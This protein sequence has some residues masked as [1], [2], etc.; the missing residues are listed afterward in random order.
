MIEEWFGWCECFPLFGLNSDVESAWV[1]NDRR[2]VHSKDLRTQ[3]SI[4]L[5]IPSIV[6][7]KVTTP[8]DMSWPAMDMIRDTRLR[9]MDILM[10][11]AREVQW[12]QINVGTSVKKGFDLIVTNGCEGENWRDAIEG[13]RFL[14]RKF[15]VGVSA[16]GWHFGFLRLVVRFATIGTVLVPV[17]LVEAKL[18]AELDG[19]RA[20]ASTNFFPL[21]GKI[22]ELSYLP[23]TTWSL[24][25]SSWWKNLPE[26]TED[27]ARYK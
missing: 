20:I 15:S 25:N 19:T 7:Q 9:S 1:G 11:L 3:A 13:S 26:Y 4:L 18:L 23:I 27:Q 21:S 22:G 5:V 2:R 17:E 12:D 6:N 8:G 16:G 24:E 14:N 10:R